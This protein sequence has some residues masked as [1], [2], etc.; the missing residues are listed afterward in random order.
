MFR[1]LPIVVVIY[2]TSGIRNDGK[3]TVVVVLVAMPV[4]TIVVRVVPYAATVVEVVIL[5]MRA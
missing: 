5:A 4:G 1:T 2:A 3:H